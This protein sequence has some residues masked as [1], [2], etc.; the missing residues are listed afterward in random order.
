VISGCVVINVFATCLLCTTFLEA[1]NTDNR[2]APPAIRASQRQYAHCRTIA[3]YVFD[4]KETRTLLSL[5]L[6]LTSS[7]LL[8]Y[9]SVPEVLAIQAANDEERVV[10]QRTVAPKG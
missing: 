10:G 3:I 4:W 9:S 1:R 2:F 6:P 7:F 8:E 5:G